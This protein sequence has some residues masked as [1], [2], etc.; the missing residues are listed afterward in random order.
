VVISPEDGLTVLFV[1]AI[2]D[3]IA[4]VTVIL[5]IDPFG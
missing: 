5:Q 1:V 2:N 3:Q 4:V